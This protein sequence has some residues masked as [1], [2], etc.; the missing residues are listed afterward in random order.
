MNRARSSAALFLFCAELMFA[1]AAQRPAAASPGYEDR[2][3]TVNGIRLHYLDWGSNGKTPFIMLHGISRIA[4]QFDH[5]APLFKNDYH[6]M[7][8]DMSGH[9]DSGWSPEGAYV[10]EDYVKDLE[11]FVDQLNLR[12]MVLLGTTPGGH[13]VQSY[14]W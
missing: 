11:A 3:L 4:H 14:D 9:G 13:V 1:Q 8:I 2:Y 12:G 5:L 10:V 7:A 6:V